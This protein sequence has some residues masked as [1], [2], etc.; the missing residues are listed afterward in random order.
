MTTVLAI[1]TGQ[2][3]DASAA[4]QATIARGPEACA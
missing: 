2:P 4:D 1:F 3:S